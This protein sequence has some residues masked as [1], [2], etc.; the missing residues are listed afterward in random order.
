ME[1]PRNLLYTAFSD[2]KAPKGEDFK[3][4]IDSSLNS[5]DDGIQKSADLPLQLNAGSD[6]NAPV[7][8]FSLQG[9]SA[10]KILMALN[11]NNAAGFGLGLANTPNAPS[12]FIDQL[13]GKISIGS[14]KVAGKLHVV[15]PDSN[16]DVGEWAEGQFV[17]GKGEKTGANSGGI[18]ISYSKAAN[19]GYISALSPSAAWRDLGLRANNTIF[20]N[21]SSEAMRLAEGGNLG[22]GTPSPLAKLHL[23]TGNFFINGG[24][25]ND[26]PRPGIDVQPRIGEVHA[27]SQN[28]LGADDGFLRLSAGGGT[29]SYTRSF[30]DLSAFSTIPDMDQ[31]IV[32]GTAGTERIRIDR[33][34]RTGIGTPSAESFFA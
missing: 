2:G 32:L 11:P 21:G 20:Y 19:A 16:G 13:T 30:I 10:A 17:V 33:L 7:I 9:E 29:N 23:A 22:L 12:L 15:T 4:L 1:T 5:S 25:A 8:S 31:N 28:G 24:V 14:T 3:N 26:H 18:G 34:G 27:Y 6:P